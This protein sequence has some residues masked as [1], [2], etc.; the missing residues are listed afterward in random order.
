MPRHLAEEPGSANL[1]STLMTTLTNDTPRFRNSP[2]V[3]TILGVQFKPLRSF[4][5][6][7]YGWF[8]SKF[9]VEAG[10]V[11][12]AEERLLP[13]YVERFDDLKLLLTQPSGDDE[14]VTGVRMKM[15]NPANKRTLQLQP[16]KLYYGWNRQGDEPFSYAEAKADFTELVQ[17]FANFATDSGLGSLEPNLWEVAYVNHIPSGPLWTEPT[18]WHKVFPKFFPAASPEARGLRFASYDGHW[19]FEIEPCLGRVH[20]QVAKVVM[21]QGTQASLMLKLTGRGAIGGGGAVDWSTG[22]DLGHQSCFDLFCAA[23][24]DDA[25]REWGFDK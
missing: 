12:V 19:H 5:A 4:R 18:D 6:N 16:D 8:W 2:M 22:L 20:A 23:I 15:R 10:W 7:H 1:V 25:K 14:P 24:S 9:L 21:N 11:V 17:R 3:E 13:T